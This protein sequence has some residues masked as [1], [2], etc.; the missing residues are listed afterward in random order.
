MKNC[1][2]STKDTGAS[3]NLPEDLLPSPTSWSFPTK[4]KL[5]YYV[6]G[7]R[8]DVETFLS[9]GFISLKDETFDSYSKRA[10]RL[11]GEIAES[12]GKGGDKDF[13]SNGGAKK[14][15]KDSNKKKNENKDDEKTMDPKKQD[16]TADKPRVRSPTSR[17]RFSMR[18]PPF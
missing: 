6:T 11:R 5:Q 2:N 8:D 14:N 10:V 17:K 7:L 15:E 3:G 4:L 16:N 9:N 18:R 1:R 13:G 12:H